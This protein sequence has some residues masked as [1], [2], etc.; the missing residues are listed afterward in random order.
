ML[1][2]TLL[3]LVLLFS[4]LN[5]HLMSRLPRR[6]LFEWAIIICLLVNALD[7]LNILFIKLFSPENQYLEATIPFGLLFGPMLYMGYS[8]KS[9]PEFRVS[10]IW[11]HITPFFVTALLGMCWVLFA[12]KQ[13]F[14]GKAYLLFFYLSIATSLIAYASWATFFV[15]FDRSGIDKVIRIFVSFVCIIYYFIGTGILIFLF[16]EEG[17]QLVSAFASYPIQE[18]L[19]YFAL[20]SALVVSY[21]FILNR[22]ISLPQANRP[23]LETP[24]T[25]APE[26]SDER[27]IVDKSQSGKPSYTKSSL[28]ETDMDEHEYRIRKYLENE[29]AFRQEGLTVVTLSEYLKIPRHYI[30][31]VFS[32]RYGKSFPV[33]V[34]ELRI[35]YAKQLMETQVDLSITEIAMQSGFRSKVSFNRHFKHH[36]GCTPTAFRERLTQ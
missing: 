5:L 7:V 21:L 3:I 19:I 12:D 27:F 36:E 16:N 30:T 18:A 33:Y 35:R 11:I 32:A 26:T 29:L 28:S 10:Q 2:R 31:Q 24:Q 13:S 14:Y 17:I 6:T 4:L 15:G 20:L 1:V 34:N 25:I 22:L 8:S 9:N 23:A